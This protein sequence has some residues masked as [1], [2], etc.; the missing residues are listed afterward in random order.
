MVAMQLEL[1]SRDQVVERR[2]A[3]LW[4]PGEAKPP[5][6]LGVLESSNRACACPFRWLARRMRMR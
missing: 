2:R 4:R 3:L 1:G 5:F 6:L